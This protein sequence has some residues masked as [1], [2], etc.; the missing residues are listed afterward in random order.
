[1][2]L[3]PERKR[4]S[5]KNT[6]S[7]FGDFDVGLGH[8]SKSLTLANNKMKGRMAEDSFVLEQTIQGKEVKRIHKGGDFVVKD[9]DMFGRKVGKPKTCEIKTGKSLYPRLKKERRDD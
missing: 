8:L 9:T 4:K 7:G 2:Y 1:M 5:R 6:Q 3:I